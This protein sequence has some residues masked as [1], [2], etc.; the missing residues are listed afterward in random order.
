MCVCS[1]SRWPQRH[2]ALDRS[3]GANRGHWI[4]K[5]DVNQ[6]K[7]GVCAMTASLGDLG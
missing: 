1:C 6:E 4:L 2:I 7:K 3:N 5:V